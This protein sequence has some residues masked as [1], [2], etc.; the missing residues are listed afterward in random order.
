MRHYQVVAA[1]VEI[2][3][4]YLCMQRG[5]TRYP[6]TSWKW[7][8]PGG[9]VE[10]GEMESDALRRE[11]LEEM[12]YHVEVVQLL[13]TVYHRYPDFEITLSAYLCHPESQQFNCKEHVNYR[14]IYPEQLTS[15]DWASADVAIVNTLLQVVSSKYNQS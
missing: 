1:V 7:E 12:D 8:F 9:K 2:D 4:A 10:V 5:Q 13:C 15:L 11:L 3:G 6:Y 14:W